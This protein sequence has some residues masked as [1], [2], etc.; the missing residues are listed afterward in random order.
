MRE[1]ESERER[2][3]ESQK[4]RRVITKCVARGA[5]CALV[6]EAD[7]FAV[8]RARKWPFTHIDRHIETR[9]SFLVGKEVPTSDSSHGK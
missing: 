4:R 3:R 5:T 7:F 6:V 9:P 2:G 8:Q 1:T